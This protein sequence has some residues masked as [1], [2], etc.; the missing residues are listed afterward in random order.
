MSFAVRI[1][2][3]VPSAVAARFTPGSALASLTRP[4]LNRALP[5]AA[6]VVSVRSGPAEGIR[7]PIY[8]RREKYYWTGVY[9]AEVQEAVV[10]LL[11]PGATVWD[12]G[13]HIG[14]FTALAE[15]CVRPEGNVHAF[16]PSRP[17]RVRLEETLRLND[18]TRVSIHPLAVGNSRGKRRIY[19]HEQSSMWSFAEQGFRRS[20]CVDCVTLDDLLDSPVF[21]MPS[22]V[23][24]DAEGE[25]LGIL[26]SSGRLFRE[27]KTSI[28]VELNDVTE[29]AKAQSFL[30]DL[31][32]EP[33]SERHWL[34]CRVV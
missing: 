2:N 33:L 11:K 21:G 31:H 6:T 5:N 17:N 18:L 22:L 15:R 30:R 9:E 3:A 4:L 23:K 34:L 16:E 13:A 10:R 25:E 12:I 20:F 8:P 24:I 28:I 26:L 27:T 29:V 32:F 19:E 14:F 1:G 7:L